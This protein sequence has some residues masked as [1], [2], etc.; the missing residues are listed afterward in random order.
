MAD[1]PAS[2]FPIGYF[3]VRYNRLYYTYLLS[4]STH[5]M[6]MCISH[7]SPSLS[8]S[9]NSIGP[10]PVGARGQKI[11]SINKVRLLATQKFS[12]H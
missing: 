4:I 3:I 10:D 7:T 11:V 5:N 6:Y 2:V 12:A 1:L 9:M 8:L